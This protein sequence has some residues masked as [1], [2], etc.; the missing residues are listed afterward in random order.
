MHNEYMHIENLNYIQFIIH[1]SRGL[2]NKNLSISPALPEKKARGSPQGEG[3]GK[4]RK[5]GREKT[6]PVHFYQI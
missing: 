6:L 1:Y 3:A 5:A 4:I 2:G